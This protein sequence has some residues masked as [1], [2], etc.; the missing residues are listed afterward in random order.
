MDATE[1][2]IVISKCG[3]KHWICKLDD[4]TDERES[5]GNCGSVVE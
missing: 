5:L 3:G 2:K 4:F 1:M